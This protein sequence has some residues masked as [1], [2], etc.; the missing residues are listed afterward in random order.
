MNKI[1]NTTKLANIPQINQ[2]PFLYARARNFQQIPS[3]ALFKKNKKCIPFN[4]IKNG[5]NS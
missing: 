3:D 4:K 5:S 2:L 1:L